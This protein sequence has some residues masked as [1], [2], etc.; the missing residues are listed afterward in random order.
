MSVEQHG[1]TTITNGFQI[2]VVGYV[3]IRL[4][5]FLRL[6][7]IKRNSKRFNPTNNKENDRKAICEKS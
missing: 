6:Y 3:L 1:N 7:S 5:S 4:L 2:K